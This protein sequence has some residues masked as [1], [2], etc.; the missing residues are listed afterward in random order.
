MSSDGL[1]VRS[2]RVSPNAQSGTSLAWRYHS[3]VQATRDRG[4]NLVAQRVTQQSRMAGARAHLGAN[5]RLEV[6][7]TPTFDESPDQLLG[8]E[9]DHHAKAVASGRVE[10]RAGSHGVGDAD[11]I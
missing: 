10:Q 4:R 3:S 9:P 1:G 8:R 5:R 11:G 2:T 6:P 7:P